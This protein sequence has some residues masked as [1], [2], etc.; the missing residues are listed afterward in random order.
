MRATQVRPPRSLSQ[1]TDLE[2]HTAHENEFR[3]NYVHPGREEHHFYRKRNAVFFAL[4]NNATWGSLP[5]KLLWISLGW[6]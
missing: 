4:E 6:G 3:E 2:D 5:G 1:E